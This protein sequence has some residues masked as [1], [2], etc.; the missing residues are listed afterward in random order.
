VFD[1]LNMARELKGPWVGAM[2]RDG[3]TEADEKVVGRVEEMAKKK[4]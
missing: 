2:V 3:A 4:G 1:F